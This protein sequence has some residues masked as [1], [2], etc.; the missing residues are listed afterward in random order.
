MTPTMEL[1]KFDISEM[2]TISTMSANILIYG[3]KQVGKSTLVRH[4]VSQIKNIARGVAILPT[5]DVEKDFLSEKVQTRFIYISELIDGLIYGQK[6]SKKKNLDENAYVFLD[7]C[8][9]EVDWKNDRNMRELI[10]N[11]RLLKIST[12]LNTS[13]SN[14][15]GKI[16]SWSLGNFDFIFI[17]QHNK[18]QLQK[19]YKNLHFYTGIFENFETFN[20]I[21]EKYCQ[22]Y[23]CIVIN[24]YNTGQSDKFEDIV[25]WY[26][27]EFSSG[28]TKA[29]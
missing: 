11:G 18:M 19:L 13:D 8:L 3:Q 27:A 16:D 14:S 15:I 29:N 20:A 9:D 10:I 6:N 28:I 12:I 5:C 1:K 7:D 23:G 24:N 17:F 22:D 25:S 21:V 4:L 2:S 26:K